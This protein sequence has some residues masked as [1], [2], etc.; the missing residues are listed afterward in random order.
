MKRWIVLGAIFVFVMVGVALALTQTATW[1]P[2]TV[3][4]DNTGKTGTF[5][6]E[7]MATMKFYLRARRQGDT[8]ARKYFGETSGGVAT[9]TGDLAAK[10]EARGLG[11]PKPGE[12]WEITVSQAFKN[13]DWKDNTGVTHV[14]KELDSPESPVALYMFPLPPD[15]VPAAPSAPVITDNQGA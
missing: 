7:E 13:P 3:S 1:V 2:S 15:R 8:A 4:T 10:F 12:W 11:T 5:T 9:W 6:P 14:G